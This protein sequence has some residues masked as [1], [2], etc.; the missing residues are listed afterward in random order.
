MEF[1]NTLIVE[2]IFFFEFSN[3][4]SAKV[5]R[6]CSKSYFSFSFFQF[7]EIEKILTSQL[8]TRRL[9]SQLNYRIR[10][11]VILFMNAQ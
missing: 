3:F 7:D 1:A 5:S 6:T 2:E 10:A 9:D 11:L 4:F 8:H